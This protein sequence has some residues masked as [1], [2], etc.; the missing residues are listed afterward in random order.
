M[1]KADALASLKQDLNTE[2]VGD[3][4][5]EDFA[6]VINNLLEKGETKMRDYKKASTKWCA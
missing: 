1:S 5:D 6:S 3:A 4:I 2:V